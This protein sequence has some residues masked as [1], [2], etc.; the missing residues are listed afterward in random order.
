M[1][2]LKETVYRQLFTIAVV[3]IAIIALFLGILLPKVLSPIYEKNIYQYLRQPLDLIDQEIGTSNISEQ[4]AYLYIQ[5]G[6]IVSSENLSELIAIN[7]EEIVSHIVD[8][9]GNFKYKGRTYYYNTVYNEYVTKIALTNDDYLQEIRK[10]ILYNIFPILFITLILIAGL[11]ISWARQLVLKI[12]HLKQKIDNID[13]EDYVD[14][15]HY[16][17]D[18]ELKVLS[19]AIDQMRLTLQQEEEYKNMMY[20]NISHDFKTPLT[21]IKSYIEAAEDGMI[22]EGEAHKVIKEQVGKLETKVHSL[23]YLNKLNYI[24]D[25]KMK[26]DS[27]VDITPILKSSIEKFKYHRPDLKWEISIHDKST[28]YKGTD[29]SW[30]AIIDNLLNNFIRYANTTIKITIKNNR[31]YF[32][33]DGPTIDES[34]LDDI[35]SPYKKGIQGQ[36]GYGL[37]IVKKT[38][39]LL[40]YEISVKN[41]KKGVTFMIK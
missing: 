22:E 12:E 21:V 7:P 26:T 9:Y 19:D 15:Y 34:V 38:I 1:K 3:I 13:N 16:Y 4:V 29:D 35:F 25:L 20:Q 10:D 31:V 41:E 33:N 17:V 14:S 37:S 32:Y 28:F 30:E 40:G 39:A 5:D 8:T 27:K 23:L 6:E 2:P 18:D 24:K 11:L 36:F